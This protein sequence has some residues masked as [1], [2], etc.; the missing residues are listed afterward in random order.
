MTAWLG[1]VCRDH[2]RRGARLGIAQLGHG[3]RDA[4]ARLAAGDWLVYYSPRTSLRDGEPL[5]AFTA[6]G[7]VADDEIWQAHEGDFHPWRRRIDYLPDVVETPIRTLS[8]DLTARPGWGA[9]L[10]RGL[11]RLTDDDFGRVHAAMRAQRV[12]A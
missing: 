3:R 11:V 9:A 6:L 2:V 8:L 4:L 10:R 12:P 5:Q 7:V 1:V